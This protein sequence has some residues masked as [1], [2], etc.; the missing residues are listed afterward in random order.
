MASS[1]EN[2]RFPEPELSAKKMVPPKEYGLLKAWT[3]P[4]GT[5]ISL[6]TR[7]GEENLR[8]HHSSGSYTEIRTNGTVVNFSSNN[9]LSYQK[10]GMTLTY[11]NNADVKGMGHA[12][13]SISHDAHIEVAKNASIMVNGMADVHGTGHVK[14]SAADISLSTTEGSICLAAE[15]DVEIKAKSGRILAHSQNAL[16]LT[17]GAGD[18]HVESGGDVVVVANG[19][20]VKVSAAGSI[21]ESAASDILETAGGKIKEKASGT[22]V[23]SADDEIKMTSSTK[24]TTATNLGTFLEKGNLV[25]PPAGKDE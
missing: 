10:G 7:K 20:D 11:D 16:Q 4:D 15:R 12:R 8:V 24:F 23:N 1:D 17:T 6:N 25:I 22:I 18:V 5:V 14:L 9:V 19:K 21:I 3:W 13:L 2:R